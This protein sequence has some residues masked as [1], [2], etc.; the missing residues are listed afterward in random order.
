MNKSHYVSQEGFSFCFLPKKKKKL[1]TSFKF[2][3]KAIEID[4]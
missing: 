1:K 2:I 3:T 4:Y